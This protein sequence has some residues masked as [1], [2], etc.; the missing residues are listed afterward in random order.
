MEFITCLWQSASIQTKLP[1]KS[2]VSELVDVFS[3]SNRMFTL[4]LS[5]SETWASLEIKNLVV[6][7][8][9]KEQHLPESRGLNDPAQL[10]LGSCFFQLI[11][12]STKQWNDQI[13]FEGHHSVAHM[14]HLV[15]LPVKLLGESVILLQTSCACVIN[16][17]H[18]V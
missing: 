4:G 7:T 11:Q 16:D 3:A 10:S 6:S 18:I 2:L 14:D 15:G 12:R 9:R 8:V 17:I 13:L 1:H 5:I